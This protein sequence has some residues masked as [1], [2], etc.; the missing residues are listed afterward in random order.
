[1]ALYKG[2]SDLFGSNIE[3]KEVWIENTGTTFKGEWHH[4]ACTFNQ[5]S[6]L[7]IY[8]D[9]QL[10]NTNEFMTGYPL[11]SLYSTDLSICVPSRMTD[12][13]ESYSGGID[14]MVFFSRALSDIEVLELY[15]RTSGI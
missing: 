3:F 15:S 2:T 6:G 4:V 7:K 12:N 14:E 5:T 10:N 8:L 9:G 1:M 11:N 13:T